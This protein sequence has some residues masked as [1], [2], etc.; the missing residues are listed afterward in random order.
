MSAHAEFLRA[1]SKDAD[2]AAR[3][4]QDYRTAELTEQDRQMLEFVE[5][6]TLYP[7]LLVRKDVTILQD[8]G[9]NTRIF[10]QPTIMPN[11]EHQVI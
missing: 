6:L 2:L 9:M 7:W 11:K 3:I 5:N 8:A 10:L 1:A 4:K